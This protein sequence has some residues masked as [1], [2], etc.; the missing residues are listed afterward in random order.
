[1]AERPAPRA[2]TLARLHTRLQPLADFWRVFRRNRAALLAV[3]AL[4][5]I[6][7][8]TPAVVFLLAVEPEAISTDVLARPSRSH[9]MG[10]DYLGRDILGR[11]LHGVNTSLLVGTGVALIGVSIGI[12]LGSVAGY[13][14][15]WV[16]HLVMRAADA[17]LIVPTFFLILS[18][19]FIFGGRLVFVVLLLG[20]T[21]WPQIA[22]IVRAEV[23]ALREEAFVLSARALGVGDAK[24][25]FR[26]I[27]PNTLPPVIAMVALL[28][29]S[30]ILTEASLSF[31]GV[32]DPNI[33]SL[34]QMLTSGLEYATSAWWVPA[35]PGGAIFLLV[36]LLN[37][38]G[39]GLNVALNPRLRTLA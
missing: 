17:L 13:Y 2:G 26:E 16:D 22:R 9:P 3:Y 5:A 39:D 32:G 23:L 20:V 4:V 25:M 10:T 15:G 6:V 12:G 7:L 21:T 29:S 28:A 36:L 33:V 30:G 18:I 14:G 31:L 27:L 34:G 35:C 11:V 24:V 38:L 19:A 8:G 1:M 37:L